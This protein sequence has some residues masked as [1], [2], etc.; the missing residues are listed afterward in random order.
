MRIVLPAGIGD[1]YWVCQKLA[2]TGEKY[3][4]EV[5]HERGRQILNLLPHLVRSVKVSKHT[6][7]DVLSKN[8]AKTTTR[9]ARVKDKGS[10]TNFLS[11]NEWVDSGGRLEDWLPDLDTDWELAK[12]FEYNKPNV[13]NKL[14]TLQNIGIYTSCVSNVCKFN[15][16][17]W[18][19]KQWFD[20]IKK[21][22]DGKE[23]N[24]IL[25]GA[26]YDRDL[27][28]RLADLLDR[29]GIR[30]T[31]CIDPI[32]SVLECFKHMDYFIGR[33]SGIG[34]LA[35]AMDVPSIMLYPW[36]ETK[37]MNAWCKPRPKQIYQGMLF[38]SPRH[39]FKKIPK[40]IVSLEGNNFIDLS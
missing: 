26:E 39:I 38:D 36:H 3:D 1:I 2:T 7:G 34:I 12:S 4:F 8:E 30:F 23:S 14:S 15:P 19:H 16:P 5:V 21:I 31:M 29:D 40:E 9:F 35:D 28:F 32:P 10:Y 18:L 11:C 17:L 24:F 33:A 22:N 20:L 13:D 37:L 6:N 27:L 25:I